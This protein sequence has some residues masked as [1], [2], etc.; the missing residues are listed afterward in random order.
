MHQ[1]YYC[2]L[3][4]GACEL[5]WV[6]LHGLKDYLDMAEIAAKYPKIHLTFNLVPSLLEQ[7]EN[8]TQGTFG[9][10]YL[11]LSYKPAAELSPEDK[12][13]IR[14]KFFSINH[15]K[16]I[17]RFARYYELYLKNKHKKEFTDQDYLDLQV[18]FNLAWTDCSLWQR[19]PAVLAAT[20]KER[21]FSEEDKLAV[22]NSQPEILKKI[23]P[24]YKDY[25][26]TGQIEVTLSPFYHPILPLLFNTKTAREANIKTPALPQTAFSYPED[27]KAQI[28]RGVEYYKDKFGVAPRGM[29]PSEE[30]VSEHILPYII[31]SGVKWIVTDEAILFKSLKK[32]KRDSALLYQSYHLKRKEGDLTVI[33]RDRNLS[34]LLGFVY[35][36]WKAPDAVDD[37]MK[38]LKNIS[39]AFKDKDTLVTIAM[40]GENAWEHYANDGHDFLNLLYQKLSE[41]DF[42]KTVTVEEY[43][44]T[45]PHQAADIKKLAA[46]SWIYGDFGKWIGNPYKVRAWEWLVEARQELENTKGQLPGEKKA[47]AIKQMHICEGSDWF[48]WYGEDPDGD[49]DRL[50]R[51][52]LKN[53]YSIIGKGSPAYLDQPMRL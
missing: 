19:L 3:L 44:Q 8:Y 31:S 50:Y 5:P 53:F 42:L 43:L 46:G 16:V 12:A 40:D 2:N 11:E 1:P 22:L 49:F 15:E 14:D 17:P 47:L 51:M 34:D 20:H 41:A 29:W 27:V 7:L 13:F 25:M 37:L 18:W 36:S 38:H 48:W 9:D 24:A 23:I 39:V 10:K 26:A 33:F 35:H 21:F 4:T 30:S 32:K 6:R 28:E 52:H 45:K